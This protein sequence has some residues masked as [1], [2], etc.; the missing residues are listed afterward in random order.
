MDCLGVLTHQCGDQLPG[1]HIRGRGPLAALHT[2][3]QRWWRIHTYHSDSD[4]KIPSLPRVR[5]ESE[6]YFAQFDASQHGHKLQTVYV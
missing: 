3:G 1:G 2:A 6:L 5:T 4:K